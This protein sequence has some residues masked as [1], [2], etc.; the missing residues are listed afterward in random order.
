MQVT[1]GLAPGPRLRAMFTLMLSV[2]G[3]SLP[4]IALRSVAACQR[5]SKNQPSGGAKVYRFIAV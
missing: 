3:T 5:R 1:D 4:N 2:L